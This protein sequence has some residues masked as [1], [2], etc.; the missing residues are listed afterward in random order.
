MSFAVIAGMQIAV[1]LDPVVFIP[2]IALGL[3]VAGRKSFGIG[4]LIVVGLAVAI[5]F[6]TIERA[7]I[8]MGRPR[9]EFAVW[10]LRYSLVVTVLAGFVVVVRRVRRGAWWA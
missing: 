7:A 8:E 3:L 4:L 6:P 9:P 5:K 2:S 10:L 1:A